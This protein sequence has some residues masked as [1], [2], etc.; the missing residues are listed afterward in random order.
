MFIHFRE[1]E[2]SFSL[3]RCELLQF[4]IS[5]YGE[6][7]VFESVN[8]SQLVANIILMFTNSIC[9]QIFHENHPLN[10]H[11]VEVFFEKAFHHFN[12]FECKTFSKMPHPTEHLLSFPFDAMIESRPCCHIQIQ[13]ILLLNLVIH[14]I[15]NVCKP[16]FNAKI[17]VSNS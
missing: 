3:P 4:P 15:E 10:I 2:H 8:C 12:Q 7:N 9:L 1:F 13:S 14:F 5:T 17:C 16:R 11:S 6:K